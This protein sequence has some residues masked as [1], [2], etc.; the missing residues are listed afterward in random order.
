MNSGWSGNSDA[1]KLAVTLIKQGMKGQEL[2]K[3]LN[4]RLARHLRL[5]SSA[6]TLPRAENR[7]ELD[8]EL[9]DE[10]GVP[11]PR[12]T[13]SLDEYTK[14]GLA[15]ALDINRK[16]FGLMDATEVEWNS[17][18]LSNAIIAGTTR[19][20]RLPATSVVG[21]DLRTHDHANLSILGA[22]TH[23]SAPVNAPSLTITA[24]AYRLADRLT[25][26]GGLD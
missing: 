10:A 11:R 5:N 16:I 23:C 14:R 25:A 6:E 21:P 15:Q 9:R 20:G 7:V 26:S 4:E 17:P 24:M 22:S 19:M 2:V 18:Y 12:V 1:S 3:T 13:F 8:K